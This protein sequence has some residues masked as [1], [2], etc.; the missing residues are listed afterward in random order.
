M[1]RRNVLCWGLGTCVL[2]AV[3][4][5]PLAA[6]SAPS[7]GYALENGD[8]NG[9]QERDLSDPV[10]MLG[11]L[12]LGSE[13]PVPLAL[14]GSEATE[15]ANGDSNGDGTIDV[16][17]P[18][19]L[20]G[21]LFSGGPAPIAACGEGLGGAKNPNP[22][23]LPPNS[24]PFGKSYGAWQGE[25]WKWTYSLPVDGHPLFDT[26]A[27]DAGQ[28]G[29]VWFTGGTFA[30]LVQEPGVLLGKVTRACSVPAGK[31]IFFPI[32]NVE[33]ATIEGNGETEAELRACANFFGGFITT[34]ECEVDGVALGN[35]LNNYRLE[36]PLFTFGPLPENNILQPFIP[37]AVAG[38]T[39][40]SVGNGVYLML[41]PLSRGEHTL[42]TYGVADLTSIGGPKFIQDIT[43]HL[44]VGP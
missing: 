1:E 23:V 33:C 36:S 32:L 5:L 29:Q 19:L 38:A 31:A 10:Y 8:V 7:A 14:C 18:I 20:L 25:W 16:S 30:V 11:Y 28:S 2:S 21:W 12:F 39:S 43:Y 35:V 24:H 34:A 17:D 44:T 26:A 27:C 15:T 4:S 22:R 6:Q 41:A 42:H 37:A 40:P 3:L 13:E 9:D